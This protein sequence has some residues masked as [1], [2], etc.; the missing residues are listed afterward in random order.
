MHA[1]PSGDLK[2]KRGVDAGGRVPTVSFSCCHFHFDGVIV[3][4]WRICCSGRTASTSVKLLCGPLLA[5]L[6]KNNEMSVLCREREFTSS[7]RSTELM[8]MVTGISQN[9]F[10]GR[11]FFPIVNCCGRRLLLIFPFWSGKNT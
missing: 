3:I 7:Q 10:A 5:V 9:W 8:S 2:L 6:Q 1:G 4:A 11:F